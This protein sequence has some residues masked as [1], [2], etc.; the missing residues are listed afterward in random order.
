MSSIDV[1]RATY[2]A[3]WQPVFGAYVA[4]QHRDHMRDFPGVPDE[5]HM[6]DFIAEAGAAPA[7]EAWEARGR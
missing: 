7:V 5:G 6:R 1:K 2:A 3:I 4:L